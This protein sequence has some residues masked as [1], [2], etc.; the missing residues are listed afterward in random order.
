VAIRSSIIV[1]TL[2]LATL[3]ELLDTAIANVAQ[4]GNVV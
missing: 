4:T 2:A 1:I 3:V